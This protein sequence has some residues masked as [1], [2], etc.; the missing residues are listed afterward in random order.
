MTSRANTLDPA[1]KGRALASTTDL[2]RQV[3]R[4]KPVAA[5]LAESEGREPL[6]TG[7]PEGGGRSGIHL[8]RSIG[9]WQLSA[10]GGALAVAAVVYL[11]YSV[12]HSRLAETTA[13]PDPTGD[14]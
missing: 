14:N 9:L 12:K 5:L 6:P 7:A 1:Q 4:R 13:D 2:G 3:L 8:R 10:F 11:G